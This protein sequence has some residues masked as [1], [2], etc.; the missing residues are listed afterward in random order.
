MAPSWR[1]TN[2]L[3]NRG[4]NLGRFESFRKV[5]FI[6]LSYQ[7]K[8]STNKPELRNIMVVTSCVQSRERAMVHTC[9]ASTPEVE[10]ERPGVQGH[11]WLHNEFKASLGF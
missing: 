6:L 9:N 11:S 2:K 4:V 8:R 3:Q 5:I 10:A 1:N 7:C